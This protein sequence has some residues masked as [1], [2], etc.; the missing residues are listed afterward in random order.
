MSLKVFSNEEDKI[1]T[2][3][4]GRIIKQPYEFGNAFQNRMGLSNYI[5]ISNLSLP[6]KTHN[7]FL[8]INEA[9]SVVNLYYL[10]KKADTQNYNTA[11]FSGNLMFLRN[12]SG[13]YIISSLIFTT[14]NTA[15]SGVSANTTEALSHV[16]ESRSVANP[17]G[18]VYI[19]NTTISSIIIGGT[20]ISETSSTTPS[21]YNT[22]ALF[23]RYTYSNQLRLL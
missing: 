15:L 14:P 7:D 11:K 23:S 18:Y 12:N 13:S 6:I 17:T 19:I 9:S 4:G 22:T 5:K 10:T 8:W 21:N 3:M 1:L 16:N 2:S 20:V